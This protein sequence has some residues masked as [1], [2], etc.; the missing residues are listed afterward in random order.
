MRT[1]VLNL[2]N[3]LTKYIKMSPNPFYILLILIVSPLCCLFSQINQDF[4]NGNLTGVNAIVIKD[5]G[6]NE[7]IQ[8]AQTAANW[9]IDVAPSNRISTSAISDGDLHLYGTA[10]YIR[11]WRSMIV[12]GEETANQVK[13]QISNMSSTG[14][15]VLR[16]NGNENNNTGAGLHRFNAGWSSTTPMWEASSVVLQEGEGAIN[17]AAKKNIK[18]YTKTG[19]DERLRV[20]ENGEV[21]IGTT[22]PESILT[23]NGRITSEEIKVKDVQGAD[24]VF[25]KDYELPTLQEVQTHIEIYKHLPDIPSATKMQQEGIFLGEMNIKLLQK[26]E[27]LT[28][29]L[30]EQEKRIQQLEKVNKALLSKVKN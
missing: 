4:Q 5:P 30:I 16:L 6:T 13:L 28:L 12:R 10:K 23:V 2:I 19:A 15:S 9:V 24:F 18:F 27:E 22:T 25:S 3:E 21:C 26:I 17:L 20:T 7:G 29:Y 14:F 1:L 11:A 8:F